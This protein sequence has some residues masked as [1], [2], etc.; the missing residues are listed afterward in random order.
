MTQLTKQKAWL[1]IIKF[2]LMKFNFYGLYYIFIFTFYA[3]KWMFIA[4]S[5]LMIEIIWLLKIPLHVQQTAPCVVSDTAHKAN[6]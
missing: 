3:I 1:Q 4:R 6:L 5:G 2:I